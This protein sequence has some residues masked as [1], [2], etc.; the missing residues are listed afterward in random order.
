MERIAI[1]VEFFAVVSENC[2]VHQVRS[3]EKGPTA[4][5]LA[6]VRQPSSLGPPPP[7]LPMTLPT[8]LILALSFVGKPLV[9]QDP[10]A[11][12]LSRASS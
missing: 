11:I 2:R 5:Y 8:F 12:K 6:N 7:S 10:Y 9:F 4:K 3:V 1:S